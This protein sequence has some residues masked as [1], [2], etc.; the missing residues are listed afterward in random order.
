MV[1]KVRKEG[2]HELWPYA[3]IWNTT[4]RGQTAWDFHG[5]NETEK[6]LATNS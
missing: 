6:A 3:H 1:Y 4:S 2:V 5:G